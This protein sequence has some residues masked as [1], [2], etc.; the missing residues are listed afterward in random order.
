MNVT[1]IP[2]LAREVM[3]GLH[4]APGM[5]VV[6]G[7]CGLGGHTALLADAVGPTGKV[8]AFDKDARN[9]AIAR[10]RLAPY[11]D[12]AQFVHDSYV[13]VSEYVQQAHAVLLDLGYSSAHVDDPSR[14]FSFQADGPLDM[15]YDTREGVTAA[16]I[17]NSWSRD[18]L[19]TIFRRYGEEPRAPQV[20]KA[21]FEARRKERITRTLQ[22][23][24]IVSSIIPRMGKIHPATRV[25]QALRIAV[26][27]EFGAVEQGI[28]AALSVLVSGGRLA[29]ITFHS[30]E[31][32][33]VKRAFLQ[34]EGAIV[35][36]KKPMIATHE[37]QRENPRSRSAKLRVIEKQ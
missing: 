14:G 2:V 35:L 16:D 34:S 7:T 20:A 1:H 12:R 4:I 5:T 18:D 13:H 15:R 31:D 33:L 23:A 30:L 3:D 17:V 8:F 32:R 25:F 24:D 28:Q 27:D 26:N 37:E 36:T 9:L 11:Q 19:A 21:I 6:D 29:V 22:L 10:E